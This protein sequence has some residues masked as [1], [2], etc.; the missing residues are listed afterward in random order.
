[1][2]YFDNRKEERED[3]LMRRVHKRSKGLTVIEEQGDNWDMKAPKEMGPFTIGQRRKLPRRESSGGNRLNNWAEDR[4]RMTMADSIPWRCGGGSEE[5]ARNG[6]GD[7]GPSSAFERREVRENVVDP[8]TEGLAAQVTTAEAPPEE[9]GR[10]RT[11]RSVD[12]IDALESIDK[13]SVSRRPT[14]AVTGTEAPTG[15]DEQGTS[16]FVD[17]SEKGKSKKRKC[18]DLKP[19]TGDKRRHDPWKRNARLRGKVAQGHKARQ[20][21][22]GSTSDVSHTTTATT[23]CV[24]AGKVAT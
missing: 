13:G 4:P 17:E 24:V 5:S 12:A 18:D 10:D 11:N 7:M 6:C 8:S 19:T 3:V 23:Q 20:R 16:V 14:R 21:S 15:V 9:T 2:D 22:A 1:V